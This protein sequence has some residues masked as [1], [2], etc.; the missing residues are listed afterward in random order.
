MQ[1][2]RPRYFVPAIERA[3]LVLERLSESNGGMT[4]TELSSELK[5]PVSTTSAVLNTLRDVGYLVR[6]Q[7][8]FAPSVRLISL[9]RR[10]MEEHDLRKIV[11]APLHRLVDQVNVTAHCGIEENGR[12]VYIGKAEPQGLIRINTHIGHRTY[13][14]CTALGKVLLAYIDMAQVRT[15]LERCGMKRMT[16]RTIVNVES[17]VRSLRTVRTRGWAFEDQEEEIGMACLAVP[18]FDASG[19]LRCAISLS[20]TVQQVGGKALKLQLS[21]ARQAAQEICA[22]LP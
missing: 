12:V 10:A 6:R 17:L 20:G 8:R 1:P 7:S 5:L 9:G 4:I 14:H 2:A 11:T 3:F 19:V 13:L 22:L 15:L 16:P 18:V 21:A